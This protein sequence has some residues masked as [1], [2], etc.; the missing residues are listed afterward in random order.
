[1]GSVDSARETPPFIDIFSPRISYLPGDFFFYSCGK[2]SPR[3]LGRQT[4]RIT[5]SHEI[6][7]WLVRWS[8]GQEDAE[9]ALMRLVM[10]EMRRLSRRFMRRERPNHTLQPTALVNEAYLLLI[11]TRDVRWQDRSH[12]FAMAA[13]I[14]RNI[15]VD[16]ARRRL[17]SK[18][19]AIRITLDEGIPARAAAS[20]EMLALDEALN[21]FSKLDPRKARVVELRIF[22]G[23]TVEE[24]AAVLK[25]SPNTVIRDWGL[26]RAWLRRQVSAGANP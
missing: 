3:G 17:R 18:R 10:P 8:D 26:A 7:E 5:A 12:F 1:L 19:G 2:L 15:L 14:M 13:R 23:M 22:G 11:G 21:A 16:Y 20:A 6:T 4:V 9:P 25:V 24:T